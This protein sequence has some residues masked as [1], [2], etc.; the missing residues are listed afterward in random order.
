VGSLRRWGLA[1][2]SLRTNVS[3]F[4][5]APSATGAKEEPSLTVCEQNSLVGVLRK[6]E[7]P[8]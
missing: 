1:L 8:D 2:Q 6:D 4:C 7:A 3:T 5:F